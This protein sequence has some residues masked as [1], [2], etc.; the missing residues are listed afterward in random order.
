MTITIRLS[1][2]NAA[3]E[4]RDAEIGRLLHIVAERQRLGRGIDGVKLLDYNGNTVGSVKVT[5]K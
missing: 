3:F 1:T 5:G 4:D 2:D